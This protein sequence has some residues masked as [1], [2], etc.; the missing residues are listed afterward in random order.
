MYQDRLN[1]VCT[2]IAEQALDA[3]LITQFQNRSYLSGWF[4]EDTEGSG[5]LL[6][7]QQQ[8]ILLTHAL[9]K[10]VADKEAVG[11]QVITPEER[12][13]S[14]AIVDAAKEHH[15]QKIGFESM[16]ISHWAYEKIHSAG[17]GIYTLQPFEHSI[18]DTLRQVKQP[19]ELELL[20]K[21]IAITDETFAHLCQ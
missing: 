5:M 6:V 20:R 10:E 14:K 17:E 9:Y 21:A 2:W 3:F 16:A 12:D 1:Q 13:Y 11:W 19:H 15:W 18:V 8:L 7:S 4:N